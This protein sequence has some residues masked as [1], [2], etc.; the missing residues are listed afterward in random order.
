MVM[1]NP[2]SDYK[3]PIKKG[4]QVKLFAKQ[5]V[6]FIKTSVDKKNSFILQLIRFSFCF[7]IFL[8]IYL[9]SLSMWSF[10]EHR[11]LLTSKCDISLNHYNNDQSM[12]YTLYHSTLM[13]FVPPPTTERSSQSQDFSKIRLSQFPPPFFVRMKSDALI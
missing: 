4:R 8:E 7:C 1:D 6:S 2:N 9:N 12:Q 3:L 11:S 10:V 13:L 5:S